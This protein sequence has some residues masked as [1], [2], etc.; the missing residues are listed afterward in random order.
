MSEIFEERP[1]PPLKRAK[2]TFQ[3]RVAVNPELAANLLNLL[4][5]A[6]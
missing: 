6:V 3:Q 2:M 5:I 4:K 1:S